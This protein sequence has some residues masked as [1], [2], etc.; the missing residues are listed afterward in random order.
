MVEKPQGKV[1]S[2]Q[3]THP[4]EGKSFIS[5]NIAS[6][7]AMNNK[8]VILIGV[9]LRKPKIHKT[10]DVKNDH[11]LSTMLVGYDTLEQVILPTLIENLYII[12]AGPIPP[13]PAELLSKP[14]MGAM[15]EKL[16]ITYDYIILDNAPITFVTDGLILSQ[17]SDLNLFVLRYG[18]SRKQQID[19]INHHGEKKLINHLA[20][21]VNDI[22]PNAFGYAYS[23]Y[24]RYDAYY[25][26]SYKKNY[27]YYSSEE[28]STSTRSKKK[29]EKDNV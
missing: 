26:Y 13:N 25:K 22:K 17:L 11:G 12:P 23:K 9:D 16:R 10:F 14:E 15:I 28:S 8:K 18:I 19:I 27:H 24:S 4:G 21:V 3:S 29:P 5:V 6:I 7:L 1:I 20:I 2:V